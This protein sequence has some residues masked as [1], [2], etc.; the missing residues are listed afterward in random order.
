M[1]H[2]Y[3]HSGTPEFTT[4]QMRQCLALLDHCLHR[5]AAIAAQWQESGQ[6][7]LLSPMRIAECEDRL[8][9]I[10][11]IRDAAEQAIV[12]FESNP[13]PTQVAN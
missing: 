2:D 4:A 9:F 11:R 7:K 5:H 1:F 12:N 6:W 13:H 8:T 3:R 10:T